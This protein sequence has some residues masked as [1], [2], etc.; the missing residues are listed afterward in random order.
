M[1]FATRDTLESTLVMFGTW[2]ECDESR[3][4]KQCAIG[5]FVRDGPSRQE[6]MV[7][8]VPLRVCS[9]CSRPLERSC[10][11]S[12]CRENGVHVRYC[13]KECQRADWGEHRHVCRGWIE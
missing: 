7:T 4:R 10:K 1:V 11:C 9:E 2:R 5:E 8:G 3:E 13:G 6:L 12:R